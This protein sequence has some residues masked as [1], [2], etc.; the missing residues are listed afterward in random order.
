MPVGC[1]QVRREQCGGEEEGRVW[2]F[3]RG[4]Q[5]ISVNEELLTRGKKLKLSNTGS[6]TADCQSARSLALFLMGHTV[7]SKVLFVS[8]IS[9][10]RLSV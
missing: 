2:L 10:S 8:P 6:Q 1:L 7:Y 9:V 4:M 3:F 5:T